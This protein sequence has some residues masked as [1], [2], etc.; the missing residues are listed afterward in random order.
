MIEL[1]HST[2]ASNLESIRA[3][4]LRPR[5]GVGNW[6]QWY[7]RPSHPGVVYLTTNPG[8]MDFHG[9]R[10]AVLKGDDQF[11]IVNVTVDEANLY[12]DENLFCNGLVSATEMGV[13]QSKIMSNQERW[14]DSLDRGYGVTH[15]GPVTEIGDVELRPLKD[16]MWFFLADDADINEFD[17]RLECFVQAKFQFGNQYREEH[18]KSA[19]FER[20]DGTSYFIAGPNRYTCPN[21]AEVLKI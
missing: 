8:A 5:D 9:L 16:S 12:P 6:F 17:F 11:M 18:F 13:A 21:R 7:Q 3:N 15:L 19:R 1:K 10:A 4:G 2:A 14:R 20:C